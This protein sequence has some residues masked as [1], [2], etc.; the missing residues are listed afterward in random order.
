MRE[1]FFD[2]DDSSLKLRLRD[3]ISNQT[4]FA[5]VDFSSSNI[6]QLLDILVPIVKLLAFY[7]NMTLNELFLET[8]SLRKNVVSACKR[9]GYLP[10]RYIS[11]VGYL[12]A[13]D[14]N[15]LGGNTLTLPAGSEFVI[16]GKNFITSENVVFKSSEEWDSSVNYIKGD[17]VSLS[18]LYY[19]C[20]AVNSNR[21]PNNS[22][23]SIYWKRIVNGL[24]TRIRIVQGIPVSRV[25]TNGSTEITDMNGNFYK[26]EL[27]KNH[28]IASNASF[29]VEVKG[30]D[31][32][33]EEWQNALFSD[34]P[35][36]S[37]SKVYWLKEVNNRLYIV[38]GNGVAGKNIPFTGGYEIRVSYI[39]SLGISGGVG[40][41]SSISPNLV[42][43]FGISLEED[44]L[45]GRFEESIE[46]MRVNAPLFYNSADRC[47][48][49]KDYI[50][51]IGRSGIPFVSVWGGEL[52]FFSVSNLE[53]MPKF[54]TGAENNKSYN[55][56]DIVS[57]LGKVVYQCVVAN[58]VV[59]ISD[60]WGSSSAYWTRIGHIDLGKA[61]ISI[62]D[63]GLI[64]SRYYLKSE[65]DAVWNNS[66]GDKKPIGFM[67]EYIDPCELVV[68]P[69]IDV[70]FKNIKFINTNYVDQ[71][72][73]VTTNY[74]LSK[75]VGFN[76]RYI[77]GEIVSKIIS[78]FSIVSN[79]IIN[80]EADILIRRSSEF[81]P[82]HAVDKIYKRIFKKILSARIANG[83]TEYSI[84]GSNIIDESTGLIMGEI[85]FNHGII[86][87]YD[88][89][90]FVG[91]SQD[92]KISTVLENG[93][94]IVAQ[95]EMFIEM[96]TITI[97]SFVSI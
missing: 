76:K 83:V 72:K 89:A 90:V 27:D 64:G 94:E 97:N 78:D 43:G 8:A 41:G 52:E 23:N 80:T 67:S 15:P 58:H 53:W 48:N 69:K 2:L 33:F 25:Y 3:F 81:N 29:I 32:V 95:K 28:E 56:G 84:S 12:T 11:A 1:M 50:A 59:K 68:N 74:I 49:D 19:E 63:H 24:E 16:D 37:E 54:Y 86:E 87:I 92:L 17:R 40:K 57:V 85:D 73:A 60:I 47:V 88:K 66:I 4:E 91:K 26:I 6:S 34:D 45:N 35:L 77:S 55:I 75:Y 93:N 79:V 31:P 39:E 71:I 22:V 21:T 61:Y 70:Y 51:N 62:L 42:L 14:S 82:Q 30:F 96:G 44:I 5:G 9:M 65:Y 36:N 13:I 20:L 10:N 7:N 38:F 18:G 46:E